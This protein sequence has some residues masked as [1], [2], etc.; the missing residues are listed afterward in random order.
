[1]VNR[2]GFGGFVQ[3]YKFTDYHK[4]DIKQILGNYCPSES[5]DLFIKRIEKGIEY[6]NLVKDEAA[7]TNPKEVVDQVKKLQKTFKKLSEQLSGLH[8]SNESLIDQYYYLRERQ[9]I[10]NPTLRGCHTYGWGDAMQTLMINLDFACSDYT[11][12]HKSIKG[13][14]GY[15]AELNLVTALYDATSQNCP[16]LKIS[17]GTNSKAVQLMNYLIDIL[18]IKSKHTK[19]RS[20]ADNDIIYSPKPL[21]SG[22]AIITSW[23]KHP[24]N[25]KGIEGIKK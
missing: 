18:D 4:K 10:P 11:N 20:N 6:Y 19:K 17:N 21:A 7:L 12:A 2:E 16:L 3:E 23:L 1:M 5:F 13:A 15:G 24:T 25:K 14:H 9:W 22:K 8:H